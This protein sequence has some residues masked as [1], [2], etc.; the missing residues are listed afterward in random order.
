MEHVEG[1]C[2]KLVKGEVTPEQ[3]WIPGP[4]QAPEDAGE[5]KSEHAWELSRL[6]ESLEQAFGAPQDVEWVLYQGEVHVVQSRPITTF[7]ARAAATTGTW[8]PGTSSPS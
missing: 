6:A 7:A 1:G 2:E 4:G 8:I 3:L 5:L